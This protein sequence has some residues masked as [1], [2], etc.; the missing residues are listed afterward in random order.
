MRRRFID[1]D[2]WQDDAFVGLSS[3]LKALWLYCWSVAD[4]AGTFLFSRNTATA[5]VGEG[6]TE[7]DITQLPD[8]VLLPNGRWFLRTLI[9]VEYNELKT[10]VKPHTK[11]LQLV[12]DMAL[13]PYLPDTY[14]IPTGYLQEGKGE[15][16]KGREGTGSVVERPS[17]K[18]VTDYAS[19]TGL[20]EWKARDWFN[21]MEGCGWLDHNKRDV[22]KWQPILD[23]VRVKWEADGRPT[24]PPTTNGQARKTKFFQP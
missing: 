6:V 15:E 4:E 16:R 5:L 18:E 11:A 10:T 12:R 24:G 2:I 20:A 22:R 17:L 9:R 8:C 1:R 13:A 19:F 7:D 23:R 14:L 3:K 21:E